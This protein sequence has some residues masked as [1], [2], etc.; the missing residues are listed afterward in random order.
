MFYI[1]F[2][3]FKINKKKKHT[4]TVTKKCI[5]YVYQE[6]QKFKIFPDIKVIAFVSDPF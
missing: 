2:F 1:F 6:N 5:V 4:I 3:K